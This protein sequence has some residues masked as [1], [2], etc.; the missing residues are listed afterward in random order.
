MHEGASNVVEAL[1]ALYIFLTHIIA[2]PLHFVTNVSIVLY[3][4]HVSI[5]S[6]E[7]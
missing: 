7:I 3:F 1:G 2:I 5:I 4:F 6:K